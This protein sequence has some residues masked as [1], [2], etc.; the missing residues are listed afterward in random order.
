M[1]HFG[2]PELLQEINEAPCQRWLRS[3]TLSE[4]ICT[5]PSDFIPFCP[6]G[7]APRQEL[8]V[9]PFHTILSNNHNGQPRPSKQWALDAVIL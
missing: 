5:A 6:P 2:H 1:G 3:A 4:E 9:L 7:K 8:T